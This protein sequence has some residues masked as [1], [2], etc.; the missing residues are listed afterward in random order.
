LQSTVFK[1]VGKFQ[2]FWI[3]PIQNSGTTA[4]DEYSQKLLNPPSLF[5]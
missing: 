1:I 2:E 3:P 5:I 4:S